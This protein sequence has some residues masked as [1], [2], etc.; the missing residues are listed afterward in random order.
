MN[1]ESDRN[2]IT[3]DNAGLD[4]RKILLGSTILAA[5]STLGTGA[6]IAQAQQPPTAPQQRAAAPAT[7]RKPNIL[8]IMPDDIGYWNLSAY[9]R[10]V[11]GYRTPHIDRIANE[12]ALFTEMYGQ[13]SC[14]PGRASFITGMYPIRS[15]LTTVGMVGD[16]QGM[17]ADVPSLAE[18]LKQQGYATGQ[19]GKNHV[20]DR[21]EHLPTV[22]GFDEFYG[23]LYHLN[24]L[25]EPLDNDYPRSARFE[26]KF[27]PRGIIHS[28]ATDTYD[29]SIP[30][31]RFG[32]VGKQ[33]IEDT[34][35]PS[36]KQ[37]E[38][39]DTDFNEKAFGFMEKAVAAN[40]PFFVWLNPSRMHVFSF[41]PE[42]YKEKAREYTSYDDPHGAGMIQ[43][44]ED[45][46][47]VLDKLDSLGIADNTIVV[48]TTDNGPEHSTYPYGGTTPFRSEKMTT[49]EGGPRVPFFVRWPGQIPAKTE[50]N[51]I[52][53]LMDVF[54]TLSVAAGV[55]Y[56]DLKKRLMAGDKLG[57]DTEK[58]VHLDG[59]NSLDYWT[60]KA[61]E[62]PRDEYIYWNESSIDALRVK[63]W[64]AHFSERDGY[65]GT[66]QKMEIV[67]LYNLHQDPFESY[68]Q[69]PRTL[70]QLPQ[71]KSWTFN[72]ILARLSAHLQTLKEYPPTQ[73][74]SSL[75]VDQMIQQ[76][77]SAEPS[78]K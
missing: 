55:D 3:G 31:E 33:K 18:V 12:G 46:G 25:Q 38:T 52:Q 13:P 28:V 48:Y 70:G 5:A 20:G 73:R 62:S 14:T 29:K 15:G 27:K 56:E 45:I 7:G 22:H 4:R 16:K 21:N 32:E 34:G 8:V 78:G 68:D 72:T 23:F 57:T 37:F 53:T 24:V 59:L 40:K 47:T 77:I 26:A 60:G 19:F 9:N 10:G 71:H 50:I 11:M 49:W 35:L 66:K 64:K 43:H 69:F 41:V 67:R 54:A 61:K 2:N 36:E 39:L 58:K 63:Q 30:D 17:Q 42:K 65:Y 74:G 76:M 44:D 75:S 6:S 51:G 1:D